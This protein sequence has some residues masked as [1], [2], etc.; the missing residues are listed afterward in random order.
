MKIKYYE[1]NCGVKANEKENCG[2]EVCRGLVD[3][4]YSIAIKAD[5]YPNFEEAEAFI[6]ED[7]KKLG[8]DGVY[9]IT[10]LTEEEL[11]SFFDT[12]NLE[13]WPVLSKCREEQNLD[14]KISNV[15]N[16]LENLSPE[17]NE[18]TLGNDQKER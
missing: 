9:G 14:I 4:E 18:K 10:P 13:N 17:V 7:L 1:L 5:H 3:T 8:Y 15:K 16:A 11:Y 6:K 12:K 2:C